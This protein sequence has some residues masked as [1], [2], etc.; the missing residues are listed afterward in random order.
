EGRPVTVVRAIVDT[1]GRPLLSPAAVTGG[2]AARRTL[3]RIGPALVNWAGA[4]HLTSA[5]SPEKGGP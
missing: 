5:A 2:L 4:A 1:P 3:R